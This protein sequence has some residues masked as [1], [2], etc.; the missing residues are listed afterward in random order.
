MPSPIYIHESITGHSTSVEDFSI[1]GREDNHFTRSIKESIYIKVNSHTLNKNIGKYILPHIWDRFL[2][3][4]HKFKIKNQQEQQESEVHNTT[5]VPSTLRW[6][7][8]ENISCGPFTPWNIVEENISSRPE[9]A[10][11]CV[12]WKLFIQSELFCYIRTR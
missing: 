10:I 4:T 6:I 3:T 12:R 2:L 7:V 9:E 1:L 5:Q 11:L 8:E